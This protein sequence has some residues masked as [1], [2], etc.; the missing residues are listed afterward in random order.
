VKKN[1]R[2]LLSSESLWFSDII[3]SLKMEEKVLGK[4]IK[5]KTIG[6]FTLRFGRL[7][8][9]EIKHLMPFVD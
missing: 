7:F 3:K 6:L 8:N 4:K 9:P 1:G 5:I 2:Y